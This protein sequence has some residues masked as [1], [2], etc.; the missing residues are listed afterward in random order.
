MATN[1]LNQALDV[2]SEEPAH[3]PLPEGTHIKP[4]SEARR[5]GWETQRTTY[6]IDQLLRNTNGKGKS[7]TFWGEGSETG[8]HLSQVGL[9]LA[10]QQMMPLSSRTHFH[11]PSWDYKPGPDLFFLSPHFPS[12]GI[13][14]IQHPEHAKHTL[15][16]SYTHSLLL[17]FSE[18][19]IF[20]TTENSKTLKSLAQKGSFLYAIR[21]V[22]LTACS[23]SKELKTTPV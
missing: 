15:P 20:R 3:Q 14:H 19:G 11:F 4:H 8:S 10:A 12:I 21:G 13:Y 23:L 16:L 5:G 17:S 9:E 7:L 1:H 18:T 2:R 22:K 6:S